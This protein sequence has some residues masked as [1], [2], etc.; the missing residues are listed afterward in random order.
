MSGRH[1]LWRD[2]YYIK[3]KPGAKHPVESWGGYDQDLG[4]APNV[5]TADELEPGNRYGYMAHREHDLGVL[6]LDLYEDAAPAPGEV[7]TSHE[8]LIVRSPS[9]G[10]HIPFL[11]PAGALART[12]TE[13]RSEDHSDTELRVRKEFSDWVDLKGELGGGH[14][15]IPF[16]TDYEV[17]DGSGDPP[18][19]TD[20]ADEAELHALANVGG[21]PLLET[22]SEPDLPQG[23]LNAPTPGHVSQILGDDFAEGRRHEHPFHG[24]SSGANFYVF[25]GGDFWYCYRHE[26]GGTLLHLI[27]MDQGR[28]D[29]GDW[30]EMAPAE[31]AEAHRTIRRE[32]ELDG[33]DLNDAGHRKWTPATHGL[34]EKLGAL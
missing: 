7:R 1:G 8:P 21:T 2:L 11:A 34:E 14:C 12:R 31:R 32:A 15:V 5:Y 23:V 27:G 24:S 13:A 30:R 26:C 6:D 17:A 29:C 33:Y 4:S 16:G 18:E 22:R 25:E 19:L 9:G 3:L 10:M 28:Y 20:P